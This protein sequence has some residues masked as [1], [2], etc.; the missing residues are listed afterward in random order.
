VKHQAGLPSEVPL[1]PN[2]DWSQD[3]AMVAHALAA[4]ESSTQKLPEFIRRDVE[5]AIEE[6]IHPKGM[7]T[8][9]GKARIGADR[10][11][12]L[13]R[14][15]DRAADETTDARVANLLSALDAKQAKIDA[16]MLEFCPG[17]MSAEQRAEWE[18]HQRPLS[19][20]E[21]RS[22]TEAFSRSPRRV[23]EK[24]PAA[25]E[26]PDG[27]LRKYVHQQLGFLIDDDNAPAERY[28]RVAAEKLRSLK[29]SEGSGT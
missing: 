10:L 23:T 25:S 18:K 4:D 27:A 12:Y 19:A 24:A 17:E 1:W 21:E 29:T 16:L 26:T 13:V 14:M 5:R 22:I 7:S 3:V 15:I 20:D 28:L 6:A 2:P 11:L 9:D 8:G